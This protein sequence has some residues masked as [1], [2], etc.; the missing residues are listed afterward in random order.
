M[1]HIKHRRRLVAALLQ[2]VPRGNRA[3]GLKANT[4]N[5]ELNPNLRDADMHATG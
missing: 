2:P 5:D 4:A 3:V 1:R